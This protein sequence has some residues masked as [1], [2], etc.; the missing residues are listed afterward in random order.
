MVQRMEHVFRDC[1][2]IIITMSSVPRVNNLAIE[3]L[4]QSSLE[5]KR[6]LKW[7][8]Y[9]DIADV[10]SSQI[11]NIYHGIRKRPYD[12]NK[13]IMLLLLGSN[14]ECTSTF[15]SEFARIYSLP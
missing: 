9:S 15:V 10:R 3:N 5:S 11:D 8:S 6:K 2:L 13:K 14:K 7:I 12:N 4:I 1:V